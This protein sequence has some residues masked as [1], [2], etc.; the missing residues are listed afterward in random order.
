MC[1]RSDFVQSGFNS[2]PSLLHCETLLEQRPLED[3]TS[4]AWKFDEIIAQWQMV[5]G[6]IMQSTTK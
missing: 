1:I 3:P 5:T 4:W 2:P 6:K